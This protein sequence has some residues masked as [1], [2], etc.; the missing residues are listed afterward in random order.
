MSDLWY[1]THHCGSAPYPDTLHHV[2][3]KTSQI[4]ADRGRGSLRE[5]NTMASGSGGNFTNDCSPIF[6]SDQTCVS[7]PVVFVRSRNSR[8]H[9]GISYVVQDII[10][11]VRRALAILSMLC[12]WVGY[13]ALTK[14]FTTTI[15]L[16]I[17]VVIVIIIL[18]F[19]KYKFFSQVSKE[20]NISAWYVC[21]LYV[22]VTETDFIFVS[23]CIFPS[24]QL[25]NGKWSSKQILSPSP[26]LLS[27]YCI[28]REITT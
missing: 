22:S 7:S 10:L 5:T 25:C 8:L 17:S 3:L 6:S 18:L 11:G 28:Y 26:F 4:C 9:S 1:N 14:K 27:K 2:T 20:A 16:W 13:V 12:W 15:S 24:Y 19:K 23:E 21:I